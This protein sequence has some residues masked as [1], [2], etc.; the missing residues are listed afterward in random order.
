ML[1]AKNLNNPK[2]S[3]KNIIYA[4]HLK[5]RTLGQRQCCGS[6]PG[7]LM[8]RIIFKDPDPLTGCFGSG[9]GTI[10]YSH[11]HSKI[12]CKGDFFKKP[13]MWVLLDLLRRKMKKRFTK[14]TV[15][16]TIPL[17]NGRV[18]DSYQTVRSIYVLDW[19]ACSVSGSVS[20]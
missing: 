9:S 6:G 16:C 15:L 19:K 7:S 13:F 17:W 20:V 11:E 8:I 3:Y 4:Q 14:I 10:S 1:S 18:P 12:Y 2:Y 5:A